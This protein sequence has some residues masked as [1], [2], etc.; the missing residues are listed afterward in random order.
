MAQGQSSYIQPL[1]PETSGRQQ[2]L[3]DH[4][5]RVLNALQVLRKE[6]EAGESI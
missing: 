5:I 4:N 2:Q 1:K 6:I 3:G